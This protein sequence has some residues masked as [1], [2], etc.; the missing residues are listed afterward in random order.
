MVGNLQNLA[1][2]PRQNFRAV[3][4]PQQTL[5]PELRHRNDQIDPIFPQLPLQI[6]SRSTCQ[7]TQ[8]PRSPRMFPPYAQIPQ[9]LFIKPPA[10]HPLK[11]ETR[12]AAQGTGDRSIEMRSHR[13]PASVTSTLLNSTRKFP[14]TFSARSLQRRSSLRFRSA[15]QTA[16]R[17]KK[18]ERSPLRLA[19]P[20]SQTPHQPGNGLASC[21]H[22][23]TR[24]FG[25]ETPRPQ[26]CR[27]RP[28][29]VSAYSGRDSL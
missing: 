27:L 3:M 28:S 1:P 11:C 10:D 4:R 22:R 6:G 13:F 29:A 16:R 5:R 23:R 25:K 19:H 8:Q 14:V 24:R 21:F 9:P 12:L 15:H 26:H 18:L 7:Q 2:F 20:D 17:I